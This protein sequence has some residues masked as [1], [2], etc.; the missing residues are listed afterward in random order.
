MNLAQMGKRLGGISASAFSRN[1]VRLREKI[2]KDPYLMLR[3]E[4]I[5]NVSCGF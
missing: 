3:F 4:R 2:E 5:K 1:K